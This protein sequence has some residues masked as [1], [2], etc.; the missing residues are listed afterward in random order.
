MNIDWNWWRKKFLNFECITFLIVLILCIYAYFKYDRHKLKLN[1]DINFE[2]LDF[3]RKKT[4]KIK[5]R[6]KPTWKHQQECT[7]IFES[8]FHT[9][10]PSVR[11]SFLKNPVTGQNLELDGYC[12][13]LK[14]AFEYDGSQHS[15]YNPHFHKGGPSEFLYQVKKDDYKTKKCKLENINLVRIPHYIHISNLKSY[16]IRELKRINRMPSAK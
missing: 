5:K 3:L 6:K 15:S 1:G 9:K 11:P 2:P 8:I 10:F 14:L 4:D 7:N 16:I 12:A 13:S